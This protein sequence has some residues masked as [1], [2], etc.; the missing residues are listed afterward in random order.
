MCKDFLDQNSPHLS[1]LQLLI[2]FE[3]AVYLIC[4]KDGSYRESVLNYTLK[5]TPKYNR[6]VH[7]WNICSKRAM[8]RDKTHLTTEVVL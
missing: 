8:Y 6:K 1:I 3:V 4:S 5:G 2:S 7:E